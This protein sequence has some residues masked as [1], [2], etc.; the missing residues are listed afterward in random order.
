MA[1]SVA[2]RTPPASTSYRRG[3]S[4]AARA[5]DPLELK[6]CVLGAARSYCS[7]PDFHGWRFGLYA[8]KEFEQKRGKAP[9]LD[10]LAENSEI[11]IALL[12]H[13]SNGKI[14]NEQLQPIFEECVE[15]PNANPK[16]T[17]PKTL[18]KFLVTMFHRMVAHVKD[19]VQYEDRFSYRMGRSCIGV[20]NKVLKMMSYVQL[21]SMRFTTPNRK[22][23]KVWSPSSALSLSRQSSA[24]S[25]ASE[26]P[27]VLHEDHESGLS[28]D[29][30]TVTE[31]SDFSIPACFAS[32]SA[33]P[34]PMVAKDDVC[35]AETSV[36]DYGVIPSCFL[37][38]YSS[39]VKQPKDTELVVPSMFCDAPKQDV[40]CKPVPAAKGG[41][42]T[43]AKSKKAL[44]AKKDPRGNASSRCS[45]GRIIVTHRLFHHCLS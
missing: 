43:L 39:A 10:T 27:Q 9:C 5:T 24:M 13:Y 20:K 30:L 14:L 38:G 8:T 41:Q 23:P 7:N 44:R 36:A 32:S 28:G 6:E 19:L 25:L 42:K 3:R 12:K 29:E 16:G 45:L 34:E 2:M 17:D 35:V 15:V 33:M 31:E 40:R 11:I 21:D 1:L 18:A 37:D 26:S 4:P 22:P